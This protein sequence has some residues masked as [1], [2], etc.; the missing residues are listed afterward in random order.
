MREALF[1]TKADGNA[2]DCFLC[3]QRC[4]IKPGKRGKCGV[5]E[6]QDGTLQS[7]VYGKLIAQ[8]VDP[9][10]K[11]PLYHFLPGTRSYSI[12][13]AGCNLR[14][15][16]CQNS[17]ISQAPREYG[18]IFGED[19]P[20]EE[21]VRQSVRNHC[22]SIAYTYTEPTIFMEYALDVARA[23]KQAGIANVFVSNGYMSAEALEAVSPCLD[24][25]NVDLK[26][27]REAFY[28]RE[29]GAGLAP[30]L[31]TLERMKKLG[32]WLEVTTLL[33]PGL[34]DDEGELKDLAGFLAGLGPETPWHVSRFHPTYQMLDRPATP[35]ESVRK[36]RDIG[37]EAGLR[38]VYTGNLPGD[39]GES[40]YCH[41][42]GAVL[43]ERYGYSTRFQALDKGVCSRCGVP[44]AGV[45][46]S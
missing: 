32:I 18:V 30:V 40:T 33:I 12:A 20:A 4:R 25:A 27:F 6:N 38:Y 24:A 19:V 43:I 42:C 45:G 41:G 16:F 34:N 10:E 21:V 3:E 44:M 37:L 17:D 46:L 26:A 15:L 1:Y 36:A 28:S 2:V 35:A 5:R 9:I 39:A 23:A 8:H 29:C 13:T 22:A 31:A 14:C 11:K 7:L